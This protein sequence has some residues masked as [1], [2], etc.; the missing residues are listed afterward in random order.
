MLAT[1]AGCDV[2]PVCASADAQVEAIEGVIRALESGEIASDAMDD[3]VRAHPPPEGAASCCRTATPIRARPR[4]RRPA[5]AERAGPGP[6]DPGPARGHDRLKGTALSWIRPRA[7]RPGDVVGVCAP[8]GRGG[9]G[10]ARARRGRAARAGLRGAC[11][12]G[13]ACDRARF[14][15]GTVERRVAELQALFAD[16]AVAGHRLRARRRRARAGSCRGSTRSSL[17]AHPKVFVGYSDV[18]LLHLLLERPGAGDVPRADGRAGA[19][20]RALR[21]AE[22][23]RRGDRRGRALR[24]RARRARSSLRPGEAR[25]RACAAGACRSWPPRRARR[26]RC[27]PDEGHRSC[28][29]EDV[30]ERPYRHRPH[31][32]A[33]PRSRAR[34]ERRARASSSAT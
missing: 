11:S 4:G 25:G 1:Q 5:A 14:T 16:D 6:R 20:R 19:G 21:P 8:G 30:D 2:L 13:D 31:A 24:D 7:L 34:F 27:K 32:H 15:A 17:R 23:P 9:R 28:F 18:T 3:A 12:P 22:L 33:A 29:L 26:G 10:P